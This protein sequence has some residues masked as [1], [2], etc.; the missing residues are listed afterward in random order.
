MIELAP[1][2]A[3]NSMPDSLAMQY[4]TARRISSFVAGSRSA[5]ELT[6]TVSVHHLAMSLLH[7]VGLRSASSPPQPQGHL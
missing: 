2:N 1:F 4:D 6:S 5:K 7:P 3:Q